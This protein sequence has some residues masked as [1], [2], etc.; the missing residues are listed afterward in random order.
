MQ[1]IVQSKPPPEVNLQ[2]VQIDKREVVFL[3]WSL[4][5]ALS[6]HMLRRH[7]SS[8]NTKRLGVNVHIC[9]KHRRPVPTCLMILPDL[10]SDLASS[11]LTVSHG[12][13]HSFVNWYIPVATYPPIQWGCVKHWCGTDLKPV[14]ACACKAGISGKPP[15]RANG[16]TPGSWALWS[17]VS[18]R[19]SK[20]LVEVLDVSLV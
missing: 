15:L 8:T 17:S 6:S 19:N 9:L 4:T 18:K 11:S 1:A 13:A 14:C 3:T 20:T 16:R 5:E 12:I 2:S 10:P 7:E